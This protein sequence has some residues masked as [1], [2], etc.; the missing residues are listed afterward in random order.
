MSSRQPAIRLSISHP[1][2]DGVALVGVLEQL[3]PGSATRG[4]KIALIL[5]GTMGHKDYLFQK[6]LAHQLPLDSFRFD[7]RGAHESGGKWYYAGFA[8]DLQD[9]RVVVKYLSDNYGYEVDLL[10]GHSRGSVVALHWLCTSEE[11]KRVG[12]IVNVSGRYRMERVLH[13]PGS[14][15]QAAFDEQ[16]FFDW[17]VTVARQPVIGRI[18]PDDLQEFARWNSAVVWDH[19]PEATDALTIHGLADKTVPAYDATIY[20]RALGAREAG[21][22]NL[23]L[24]E[25]ADH[26][27]TGQFDEVV[28]V[29]LEWWQKHLQ[30]DLRTGIW[31][32]GNRTKL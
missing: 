32:T 22:H 2:E 13:D 26:N 20:A 23:H 29:I 7:F 16:G 18:T 12:G 30:G 3:E 28:A 9:L 21:T 11:G 10:V 8:E 4:R 5:H 31:Q 27:L 14:S 24:I 6:R 15:Y 25:G 19:F 1:D 17:K